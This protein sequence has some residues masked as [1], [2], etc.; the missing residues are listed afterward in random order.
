MKYFNFLILLVILS[1]TSCRTI[2]FYSNEPVIHPDVD[3]A[4]DYNVS[5]GI[6]LGQF[7]G[8][9]H[10]NGNAAMTE[11]IYISG[12]FTNFNGKVT[13]STSNSNGTT[14]SS[15]D[16]FK[17]SMYNLALGYYKKFDSD[18]SI[19]GGLG[20]SYGTNLNNSGNYFTNVY[21][22]KY[23]IQPGFGINKPFFDFGLSFRLGLLDISQL[24]SNDPNITPGNTGFDNLFLFEPGLTLSAG[25]QFKAGFQFS[26]TF[27]EYTSIGYW[28]AL[29]GGAVMDNLS[30]SFFIKFDIDRSQSAPQ[31]K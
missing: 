31:I 18:I 16:N 3:E 10:L 4:G 6:H 30:M 14:S 1:F 9:V 27:S 8:G 7:A 12:S 5:G 15:S 23:Y 25:G 24:K 20:L 11:N 19:Y 13:T 2:I 17:G 22:N 21:H 29:F 28:S 26:Y